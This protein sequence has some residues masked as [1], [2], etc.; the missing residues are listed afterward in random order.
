LSGSSKPQ[1]VVDDAV[2]VDVDVEVVVCWPVP[3]GTSAA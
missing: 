2:E 1:S 3:M